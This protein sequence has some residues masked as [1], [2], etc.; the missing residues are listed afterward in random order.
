MKKIIIF[1][2]LTIFLF[3]SD[4]INLQLKWKNSFQFAGFYMAKEKNY[5]KKANLD[6]NFFE[7]HSK[8]DV[9]DEVLKKKTTTVS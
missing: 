2:L 3:A 6:V 9:I 4:T 8:L 5:Y 7:Y 1:L